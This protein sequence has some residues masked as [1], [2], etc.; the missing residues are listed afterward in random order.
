MTDTPK[1]EQLTADEDYS[2]GVTRA[3]QG[4]QG[5]AMGV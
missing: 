4:D 1:K 5:G 2:R 3:D